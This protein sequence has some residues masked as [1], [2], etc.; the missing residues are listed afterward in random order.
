MKCRVAHPVRLIASG[1]GD[2]TRHSIGRLAALG[3][4]T[5]FFECFGEI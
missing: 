5:W 3:V 4:E 1:V 2:T